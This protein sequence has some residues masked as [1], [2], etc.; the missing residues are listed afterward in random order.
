MGV[1]RDCKVL[2][3][4]SRTSGGLTNGVAMVKSKRNQAEKQGPIQASDRQQVGSKSTPVR[5]HCLQFGHPHAEPCV[6][7][8]HS[9]RLG[10]RLASLSC[11]LSLPR[12]CSD[13]GNSLAT[14]CCLDLCP[15]RP[16]L[17][18]ALCKASPVARAR[19]PPT[20]ALP[21]CYFAACDRCRWINQRHAPCWSC[22]ANSSIGCFGGQQTFAQRNAQ[23][24]VL[25]A[26]GIGT[27]KSGAG[28]QPS[29][30]G[31]SRAM[32]DSYGRV[33][34]LGLRP[35]RRPKLLD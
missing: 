22:A 29:T 31:P 21:L 13:L 11:S 2:R 28:S 23:W 20:S 25:A 18:R 17:A 9:A 24:S 4:V 8:R 12:R 6:A 35:Q 33:L 15:S 14:V 10:W 34:D 1:L 30:V 7:A 32:G 5:Q 27:L 26:A 19:S 3:T 16:I